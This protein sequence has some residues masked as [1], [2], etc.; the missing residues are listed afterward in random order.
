MSVCIHYY[1]YGWVEGE[2]DK[3]LDD[4][5]S[6]HIIHKFNHRSSVSSDGM[7]TVVDFAGDWILITSL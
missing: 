2:W 4:D 6:F 1:I 5:K 7:L 3:V